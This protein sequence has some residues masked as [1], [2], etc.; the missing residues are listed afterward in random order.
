MIR[1]SGGISIISKWAWEV[2]TAG[3]QEPMPNICCLIWI[4]VTLFTLRLIDAVRYAHCKSKIM[5]RY[6]KYFLILLITTI[7]AQAQAQRNQFPDVLDSAYHGAETARLLSPSVFSDLGAWHAYALPASTKDLG[8]FTGPLLM[9]MSG[10]W[11]GNSFC[12]LHLSENGQQLDLSKATATLHYFPG[13]LEQQ[14]ELNGWKI[15]LQLIFLSNRQAMI[16]TSITNLADSNRSFTP[17][18]SGAAFTKG[19][20]DAQ[21]FQ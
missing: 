1:L 20:S 21:W 13:L 9:D 18:Y 12:K 11:L 8:G 4:T 2:I 17:A 3:A 5:Y 15:Q 16:Q 19:A 10:K 14:L 6:G 7:S